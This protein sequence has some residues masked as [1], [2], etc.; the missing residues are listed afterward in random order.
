[1]Y[2]LECAVW[3]TTLACNM[4]C[5]HCGSEAGQKRTNEL[6]TN[7]C[8]EVC[9]S[10]ASLNCNLVSLMGGEPFV[11]KDWYEIARC[12]RDLSMNVAW[13]SNGLLIPK[14]ISKIKQIDPQVVGISLDGMEV[15][16]DSIRR[17]GSFAKCIES[18]DVLR[19]AEIET[20][21]ITTVS[22]KN[23][24]ELSK[25]RKFLSTKEVNWQLQIALP[26]GN[27]SS[28][29]LISP[30]Q[31]YTICEFIISQDYKSRF[32][33]SKD[34]PY[35]V[36]GGHGIGHFSDKYPKQ[37]PFKGCT[38]GTEAIGITSDGGIVGCLSMG[39]N[40]FIEG[41]IRNR[42]LEEIWKDPNAFSYN[43]NYDLSK[44]GPN[45]QNCPDL[46]RCKGGCSATSYNITNEFHNT[47]FCMK[48]I[49]YNRE[50][51]IFSEGS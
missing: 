39:N 33:K 13:V 5:S 28:E 1:M 14:Y 6:S 38:A 43:R 3:E 23:I 34:P 24:H 11:R 47:P 35:R 42:P 25:V 45:C 15:T 7:E 18:I 20:T 22:R 31:F 44:V 49:E 40:R 8:F 48:R 16:H 21:V 29:Y 27:F 37:T 30:D 2:Q 41:N 17:Q 19:E 12:A 51:K 4:N 9:Q 50:N 36:I 32:S 46:M 26:V 10:L